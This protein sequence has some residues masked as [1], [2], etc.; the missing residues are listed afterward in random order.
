[1]ETSPHRD[2]NNWKR[3]FLV[4]AVAFVSFAYFYGGGGWNQNSRF[5]LLRAIFEQHTLRIDSYHENTEDKAHFDGHYYSDKAPGLVF[6]ALPFAAMA[7]AALRA[8]GINP[9]SPRGEIVA[10]SAATLGAV[11]L[12]TALACVC[13]FFVALRLGSSP[14]G[15]AF[16]ALCMGLGTPL[17]A[18]SVVLWAHALVGACLLFGFAA[19]LKLGGRARPRMEFLLALAVGLAAGWA[20]VTEYPAAPAAVVLACFALYQAW[21]QGRG[22]R[23]RVVAGVGA[24]TFAC[25]AVLAIYLHAAFGSILRPSYSYY[26]PHSFVFMHQRGYLGLTYPH[27]DVLLKILFG[28]RRGLFFAAPVTAAAPIG[29][30]FLWKDKRTRPAALAAVVIVIYYFLFNAS[31]YQWQA[32]LSFGP[33]YAGAAI[34]LLCLGL[35]AVWTSAT[36]TWRAVLAVLAACSILSAL[37]VVSTNPQLAVQDSCP[38]IHS[39]WPAFWSGQMSLNHGSMLTL[40]ET[41]SSDNYGAFNLGESA[42]L[43]GLQSL[44]PLLAVW[45]LVGIVWLR[46]E[47]HAQVSSGKNA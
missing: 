7:R 32:G 28:C 34:P 5:D 36:A 43:R 19:A 4:G 31:F 11:A 40:A 1:M 2:S 30:G 8:S 39:V 15:A 27:I 21:P 9:E 14:A 16:A 22:Q 26:D 47:R 13:L 25:V 46:M 17:W 10:S 41:G 29:L 23:L 33:R 42:G 24:G 35:A 12:P 45:A 3:A 6:L 38:M 37:M 44:I 20:V 18:Y